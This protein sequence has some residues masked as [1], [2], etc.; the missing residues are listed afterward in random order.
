MSQTLGAR[1]P[2]RQPSPPTRRVAVVLDCVISFAGH[3]PTLADIVRETA[4]PR[5]TVH[6]IVAE[7]ADLG[8]LTR[9]D[10]LTITVG[11][12]FLSTARTAIGDDSL[13]VAARPALT[14]LVADTGVIAFLA[15]PVDDRTITVV[16]YATPEGTAA[17]ATDSWAQPGRPIRL[18][19]PICREFVAWADGTV[20]DEWLARAP[21][22]DRARLRDVL[23]EIADRGYSI[24]RIT[25]GHRTV[26]DT[27]AGLDTVPAEL[28]GRVRDLLGELSTIDY[29]AGELTDDAEVG[30]VTIGAPIT[31][32]T[33]RVVG[34]LVSCPHTTMDGRELKRWGELVADAARSASHR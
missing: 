5:A 16:E 19:P 9:H 20:R 6:A 26:I 17:P 1:S 29:L 22:G 28:R 10:D 18:H 23:A 14:R 27:L 8:W 32:G 34:A 21:E 2:R 30:A 31:D 24:E 3:P 7:L 4:L 33:G 25:D 15:R 12:A 13:A 11:P